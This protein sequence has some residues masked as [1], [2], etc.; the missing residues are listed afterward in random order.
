[1]NTSESRGGFEK[2]AIEIAIKI[3]IVFTLIVWSVRIV[4]PFLVPIIWGVI[5][6]VAVE[7]FI[8]KIALKLGGRR[9][10]AAVLFALVVIAA[11]ILPSVSLMLNSVDSVQSF[12][13]A[14]DAKTLTVPPPPAK[15]EGWPLIGKPVYK[16]WS[17][18]SNNLA[19]TLN[20]YG[21]QIRDL[22][23]SFLGSVGGGIKVVFMFIISIVISAGLLVTKDKGAAAANKVANRLAGEKGEELVTL[24]TATIRGVMKGVIGVAVIQSVLSVAGMLIVSIPAAG[25]W[26]GLV[27]LLAVMQLPPILVLGPLAAWFFSVADTFP[28]VFFLIWSILVSASDGVLK[29]LLMGRGVDIP[30]LVILLG[31]LGGMISYGIIGLFVGAIVFSISYTIFTAWVSAEDEDI[32]AVKSEP[33]SDE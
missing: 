24:A 33:V 20:Q 27:L 3:G 10:L 16:T 8:D 5:I 29:P 25:L 18:A 14:L 6:A 32:D 21:P 30:M 4:H 2:S 11:L 1:M 26:A 7:P 19:A 13:Q 15:V 28:A 23:L 9:K 17:M 31:A 12:T 22:T